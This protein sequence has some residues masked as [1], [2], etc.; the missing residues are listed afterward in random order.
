MID[1]TKLNKSTKLTEAMS[2]QQQYMFIS[3][4]L[5]PY[6]IPENG[7]YYYATIG[8][9]SSIH[10]IVKVVGYVSGKG[11][12]VERAQ[13]NTNAMAHPSGACINVWWNPQQLLDFLNGRLGTK[14]II[15]E[16]VYCLDCNSCITVN[17]DGTI[18]D[19]NG[20]DK[21]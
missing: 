17:S 1:A 15:A 10:E 4:A 2:I 9:N 19:I 13:D 21:C 20:V 6:W 18:A 3:P 16:G 5:V 11:L 8:A 7:A 14:P 12:V